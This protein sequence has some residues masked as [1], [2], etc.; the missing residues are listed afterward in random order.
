MKKDIKKEVLKKIEQKEVLVRPRFVFTLLKIALVTILI[1]VAL[2]ALYIFNL[3]FYLP[4]R[5]LSLAEMAQ[6]PIIFSSIPWGLVIMGASLVVLLGYLYIKHEGGY[7]RNILWTIIGLSA[8]LILGGALISVT[9]MNER[10]ERRPGFNRF[11]N[12]TEE[13]FVPGQ[14]PRGGRGIHRQPLPYNYGPQR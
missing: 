11:Y 4:R 14:G 2:V 6:R 1:S 9:Q 8:F 10:L 5:G 12:K 13:R 3:S 7:K